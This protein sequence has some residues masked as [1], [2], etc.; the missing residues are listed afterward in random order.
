M[1]EYLFIIKKLGIKNCFFALSYKLLI[2]IKFFKIF[3]PIKLCPHPGSLIFKKEN[4][5]IRKSSY[6]NEI[7]SNCISTAN[8]ILDGYFIMF[9][10]LQIKF[11]YSNLWNIGFSKNNTNNKFHWSDLKTFDSEDIKKTWDLSRWSWAPLLARAF[12][13]TNNQKYLNRLNFLITNWCE[14]NPLNYGPNWNCGQEVA[15]RLIHALQAWKLLE[16]NFYYQTSSEKKYFIYAHLKRISITKYYSVSQSNNHWI[17]E[18]AALF[19]GGN[20]L[21]KMQYKLDQADKFSKLGRE[22]LEAAISKLIMEDGSFSQYSIIYHRLVLET[23]S[24]VELWR[25][26]LNLKSFSKEFYEKCSLAHSWLENFVDIDTGEG[27]N[28][29]SNDG[30]NCYKLHSQS[31]RDFRPTIQLSGLIFNKKITLKKGLWDEPIYWLGLENE[32]KNFYK[33][34]NLSHFKKPIKIFDKGGFVI[35]FPKNKSWGLLR[36]PNYL[37]RPSQADPLHFDLW[38]NGVNLLRDGGTFSYNTNAYFMNYFP[39]VESH[40]T[41]QFGQNQPMTRISRFLW[42]RWL[43]IQKKV[44][45]KVVNNSIILNSFYKCS[46][47]SHKRE[48]EVDQTGKIWK[49][50][51]YLDNSKEFLTLRWRLCCTKWVINNQKIKSKLAEIEIFST[52]E[53]KS[54]RIVDGYESLYYLHK[55]KLPVL[56]VIFAKSPLKVLTLIKII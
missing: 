18:A 33:N 42:G 19:I 12:I 11:D 3:Y 16:K 50:Y 53:I 51:D 54:F 23:L 43:S 22:S 56:E 34:K 44:I 1:Y 45:Y 7:K 48:I 21:K 28:L 4:L 14:E 9:D 25:R 35:F 8:L 47:G 15:I 31:Y 30:S 49:I 52:Q 27:P 29:G 17:S 40:N 13:L 46:Y 24:Q 38:N 39:G 55:N 6:F 32:F 10:Y 36:L 5:A 26:W 37:F 20:I 2:K 41:V